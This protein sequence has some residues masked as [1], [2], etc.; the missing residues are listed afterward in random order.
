[1]KTFEYSPSTRRLCEELPL[2]VLVTAL[3][4]AICLPKTP[5]AFC[6]KFTCSKAIV[7]TCELSPA[8]TEA[9]KFIPKIALLCITS[10][11]LLSKSGFSFNLIINPRGCCSIEAPPPTTPPSLVTPTTL[12]TIKTNTKNN[13]NNFSL[14]L[15][16]RNLS[17]F[18]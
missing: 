5:A 9:S 4:L 14:I 15:I 6:L 3:P 13:K 7:C 18:I 1:M 2:T 10:S 11:F 16:D 8:A 17:H 12:P